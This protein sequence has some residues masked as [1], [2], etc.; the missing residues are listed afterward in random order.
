[1]GCCALSGRHKPLLP[2]RLFLRRIGD[3]RSPLAPC[4]L[5]A[6][7][8]PRATLGV[9]L[10]ALQP[11]EVPAAFCGRTLTPASN[12]LIGPKIR[13]FEFPDPLWNFPVPDSR[14]FSG[15]PE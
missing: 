8:G 6:N 11:F 5:T 12:S 15:K 4:P 2:Q 1:M 10:S 9:F 7:A 14:E 3:K 13:E